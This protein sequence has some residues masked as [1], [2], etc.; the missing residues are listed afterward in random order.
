MEGA[1]R[2]A[3]KVVRTLSPRKRTHS[4]ADEAGGSKAERTASG[5][6]RRRTRTP[7]GAPA[8]LPE[9]ELSEEDFVKEWGITKDQEVRNCGH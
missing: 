6:R 3:G 4:A 9:L 7:R 1:K 2:S 5:G 8:D